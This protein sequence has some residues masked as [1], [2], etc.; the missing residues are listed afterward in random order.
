MGRVIKLLKL[1]KAIRA[2]LDR[3]LRQPPHNKFWWIVGD[4]GFNLAK[5]QTLNAVCVNIMKEGELGPTI[6]KTSK[7]NNISNWTT[8]RSKNN[9]PVSATPNGLVLLY[10]ALYCGKRAEK[11]KENY[12]NYQESKSIIRHKGTYLE[13]CKLQ[14]TA[15]E[16]LTTVQSSQMGK[17]LKLQ[18]LLAA[19]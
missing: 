19:Q 12:K 15:K 6:L 16:D 5:K 17:C 9:K 3:Y 1:L 8:W 14:G 2:A 7:C 18:I 11:T 4:P 13:Q 10:V